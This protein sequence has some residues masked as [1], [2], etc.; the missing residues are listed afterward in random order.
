[1][2]K[3]RDD[4]L[5]RLESYMEQPAPPWAYGTWDCALDVAAAL[6]AMTG[7]DLGKGW[8]GAYTTRE[9]GLKRAKRAGYDS[10]WDVFAAVLKPIPPGHADVGDVVELPGHTLGVVQGRFVWAASEAGR[11]LVPT[12]QTLRALRIPRE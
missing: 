1:M 4:W 11:V 5:P 3:L 6:E 10:H 8:R 12:E 7:T 9:G 2:I